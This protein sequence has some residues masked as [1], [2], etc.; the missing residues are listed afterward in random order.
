MTLRSILVVVGCMAAVCVG[1]AS[2]N[3]DDDDNPTTIIDPV[4]GI[5]EKMQI[6]TTLDSS[7]YKVYDDY[8]EISVPYSGSSFTL[9]VNNYDRWW[10]SSIGI[11]QQFVDSTY[12]YQWTGSGTTLAP[13]MEYE[14]W[15]KFTPTD[16]KLDCVVRENP[17]GLN[18]YIVVNMT[19]GDIF[20][21]FFIK[22]YG[23][24]HIN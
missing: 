24:P 10:V 15:Y 16:K 3:D 18:R 19:A 21:P 13:R 22:Q 17:T 23:N 1:F 14:G 2:C 11:K 6:S 7:Q 9:Q 5:W 12:N 8:I 20:A 4:I